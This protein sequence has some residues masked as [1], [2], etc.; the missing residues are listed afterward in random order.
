MKKKDCLAMVAVLLFVVSGLFFSPQKSSAEELPGKFG[1]RAILP[2]NQIDPNVSY[3]DLLVKP[4]QKQTIEVELQN[5]DDKDRDFDISINPAVTSDGGTIDYGQKN[6]KLDKSAPYDLRKYVTLESNTVTIKAKETKK[7]PIQISLP[8]KDFK[9]RMLAGITVKPKEKDTIESPKDDSSNKS[10]AQIINR[11]SYSV[12]IVLQQS[13]EKVAPDLKLMEASAKPF[14]SI[15][16]ISFNFQNPTGTIISELVFSTKVY[17]NGKLFIENTSNPFLV[18][19]T[20]N[21]NLRL[22]LDGQKVASGDYEATIVAKSKEKTWT[23]K[24]DFTVTRD[25]A[26]KVNKNTVYGKEKTNW[27]IIVLL[28]A[29]IVSL[30]VI[31]FL[32]IKRKKQSNK[33]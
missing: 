29:L 25:K 11:L 9:G 8:E 33:G 22:D 4:S 13:K 2:Q 14:N 16:Y 6:A 27:L 28:I 1:V 15:P 12:A 5:L 10:K 21:F 19:P 32:I 30:G 20:S 3:F 31:V 17:K 23:F 7:V 26:A 24:K 18:A